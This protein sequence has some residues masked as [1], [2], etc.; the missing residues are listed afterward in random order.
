[1]AGIPQSEI[2]R[3]KMQVSVEHLV[4]GAGIELKRSGKDFVGLSP[5]HERDNASLLVTLAKKPV[6]LLRLRRGWQAD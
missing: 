3:L 2:E 4:E 5:F 6:A 1:M